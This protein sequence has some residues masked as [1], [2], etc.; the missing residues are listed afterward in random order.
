[1]TRSSQFGGFE[2]IFCI[3]LEHRSDRREHIEHEFERVGIRDF[4]WVKAFDKDS[5]EVADL[6]NSDRVMKYPPCFR[7][8]RDQCNCA[9]KKLFPAQIGNWLSHQSAWRMV[10]GSNLSLICEDDV[11][12]TERI[13][14][15]LS[16]V[17][18]AEELVAKLSE[19][20]PVLV[21]LGWA[22]TE[23]HMS[24]EAFRLT[25]NV[26][27]ANP[28]Y[29]VNEEMAQL[30]ID[31][32]R[33]IATTSDVFIHRIIGPKAAHYTVEPPAA[34]E[35]SWS[36][37]EL[38][39]EIRPK[40]KYIEQKLALLESLDPLD[41]KYHEVSASIEREKRRIEQFE[42]FNDDR[43]AFEKKRYPLI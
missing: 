4:T 33:D 9:N 26:Q 40:R 20:R 2:D 11:K 10:K 14:G 37:G 23:E 8:G 21:R 6:F 27:M 28:C 24:Q 39:S 42:S 7:C 38:R 12:F 30:L 22:L 36:T 18:A 43:L 3:S 29:A 19:G 13:Q 1:M 35:L 15:A 41:A 31:S 32:L 17:F 34:Y 5:D 25:Q 16:V